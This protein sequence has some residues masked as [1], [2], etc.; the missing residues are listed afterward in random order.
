LIVACQENKLDAART[1]LDA[2]AKAEQR[3][4]DGTTALHWAVFGARP[5]EIH[6]YEDLG[7]PHTTVFEPQGSAPLVE[8]LVARGA[9]PDTADNDGNT[10]LH[11][12][13]MM[14]AAAA[15]KV[16]VTAGADRTKKNHDG[17]TALE[18]A[19]VRNNSVVDVLK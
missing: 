16:L 4:A 8:L 17:K 14:D 18:L 1:L 9:H 10:A 5:I 19:R 11:Q 13:A 2:G 3:D 7:K 12:A 6:M 15:A